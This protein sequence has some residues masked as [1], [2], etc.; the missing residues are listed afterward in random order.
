MLD[1]I[2]L[3]LSLLP[4]ND[5][6]RLS[7]MISEELKSMIL[8]CHDS[9]GSGDSCKNCRNCLYCTYLNKLYKEIENAVT[10]RL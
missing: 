2:N 6:V 3:E 9:V 7:R 1:G 8:Q 10:G 4:T 5:L